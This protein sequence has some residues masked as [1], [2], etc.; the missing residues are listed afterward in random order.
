MLQSGPQALQFVLMT[1]KVSTAD[2][3]VPLA[4]T[5]S[6]LPITMSIDIGGSGL[7]A[8]LLDAAGKPVSERQRVLTPEVPTPDAILAGLD[9]LRKLM[10]HFDRVSIGFPGVIKSGTTWTAANLHPSWVAFPLQASLEKR[11]KK[12]VRVCNDAAVQGYGAIQGKGVEMALTLGTGMGSS[13]FTN[14]HLCPGL[15]LGHHPWRKKGMTYEDYLGRR[16]LDKFGKARW[17]DFLQAAIKQTQATFNWDHLYLG[18]GNTKKILFTPGPNVS[19]VS[20]ETGLLG[21]VALWR[22]D[23]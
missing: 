23:G 8:M 6:T 7:K 12:P 11:W 22:F 14:G 2:A 15:E 5:E 3:P 16:G 4:S 1:Q 13:L 9:E 18:G 19:I 21:G 20:N 10:G 17:N